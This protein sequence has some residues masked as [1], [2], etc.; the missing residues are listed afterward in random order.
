[1]A[2]GQVDLSKPYDTVIY[3]HLEAIEDAHRSELFA[4]DIE[5]L[6]QMGE[7]VL[8]QTDRYRHWWGPWDQVVAVEESF[9]VEFKGYTIQGQIDAIVK[10]DGRYF[11]VERKWVK[12]LR[13]DDMLDLDLQ[14]GVYVLAAKSLGYD[15]AGVI[16]DQV[17]K[18]PTAPKLNKNGTMSRQKVGDKN[19]YTRALIEAGLDPADYAD[20]IDG[21]PDTREFKRDII[22][23]NED[24]L[25]QRLLE[26]GCV[27]PEIEQSSKP[28]RCHDNMRCSYCAYRELCIEEYRGRD[29]ESLIESSF[30]QRPP[31]RTDVFAYDREPNE[32]QQ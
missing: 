23:I 15:I 14:V 10:H 16:Y 31:G 18:V 29:V 11:V 8:E 24:E 2:L 4:E 30:E 27:L 3:D 5:T 28:I 26:L 32:E 22:V 13:S 17:A 12:Y 7:S 19:S 21:L 20:V 9:S 25:A 1:L 6:H